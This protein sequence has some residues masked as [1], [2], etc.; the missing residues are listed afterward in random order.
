MIK[1]PQVQLASEGLFTLMVHFSNEKLILNS[2]SV[3][4]T[5]VSAVI[6]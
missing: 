6:L 3:A 4:K 2:Q 1:L 5:N